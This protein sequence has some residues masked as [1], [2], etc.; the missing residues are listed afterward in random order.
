MC[1]RAARTQKL[2]FRSGNRC[3]T[4]RC[5]SRN[6]LPISAA[7]GLPKRRASPTSSVQ[8]LSE[9]GEDALPAVHCG[10]HAVLR[11]IDREEG[12]ARV[13]VRVKLVGLAEFF[14]RFFGL[15]RVVR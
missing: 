3:R 2:D 11:A 13:F 9:P 8:I 14:Q 15:L 1:S 12:M 10:M 4:A 6:V 7:R 5:G